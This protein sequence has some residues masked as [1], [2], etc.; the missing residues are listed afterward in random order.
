MDNKLEEL[1]KNNLEENNRRTILIHCNPN[2]G[3]TNYNDTLKTTYLYR[4]E[5]SPRLDRDICAIGIPSNVILL[6]RSD[7][8]HNH[9]YFRILAGNTED[10]TTASPR[11]FANN[12]TGEIRGY[13]IE[14]TSFWYINCNHAAII[15]N[16]KSAEDAVEF[17]FR[18]TSK[19][20]VDSSISINC[21]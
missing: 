8:Q 18:K 11:I 13:R 2:N 5:A 10:L 19:K 17:S 12:S 3:Y 21:Q 7:L 16:A 20:I 14:R 6:L 15:L 4:L 9:S 1:S